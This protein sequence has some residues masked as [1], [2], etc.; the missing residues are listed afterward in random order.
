MPLRPELKEAIEKTEGM[1]DAYRNQLLKTMEN[2]PD[3]L[4]AGWLRQADYDRTMNEGKEELKTQGEELKAKE[5]ALEQKTGEWNKWKGDADKIVHDN[6]TRADTLQKSLT[7]RD[8][9]IVELEDKIRAGDFSEGSEG[10][11]LKEV[12]TLRGEI[13]EL[14]TAAAN[15]EG[16]F[17]QEM[18]EKMLLEGGN[19]LAG[20]IYDNVFLL[21][22]LN[23]SHTTEF[24]E[25]L[26]REAFIKFATERRMVGT[27][28]EFKT[29]YDLFVQ[30]KRTEV[31]IED[32]RKDERTK[33]ES[34]MQF[35]LDNDGGQSINKGPVET[36]LQQLNRERE[37][38]DSKMTLSQ[39]SAAAAAELRKEGKVTPD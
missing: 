21:M 13:K 18:A 16:R 24:K 26:D 22:D 39:A 29:A 14:R 10:E 8:E 19:R 31:K 4:Q 7:E 17:T 33:I 27:Q 3:A 6:V 36:R 28:E 11:M 20:N 23:Q 12:T 5:E 38:V 25:G 35:P 15:G 37:G 1:T 9:K 34:K 32:A 2:A 30:D